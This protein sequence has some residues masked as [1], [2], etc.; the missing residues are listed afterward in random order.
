MTSRR[1]TILARQLA[2]ATHD[3]NLLLVRTDRLD[4]WTYLMC[5]M[6]PPYDGEYLFTLTAPNEYPIKPPSVQFWT[7]NGLFIPGTKVC[8]SIGEYH[9]QDASDDGAYGWRPAM[10]MEGFALQLPPLFIC[11]D[12]DFHGIGIQ[13]DSP[14]RAQQLADASRRFN[15]KHEHADLI[16]CLIASGDPAV[17]P[18]KT[19]H[20]RR[21][22]G[23]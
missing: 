12:K 22:S 17:E 3:Q 21:R 4:E 8:V 10:G 14:A 9:S 6:A 7:P 2:K 15:T 13:R 5:G 16:E 11:P 18:F 1:D 20:A 23:K 19:L